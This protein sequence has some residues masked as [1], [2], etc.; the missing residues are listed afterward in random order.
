MTSRSKNVKKLPLKTGNRHTAA[1]RSIKKLTSILIVEYCF[2][3][4]R[5][6]MMKLAAMSACNTRRVTY[7]DVRI[8]IYCKNVSLLP[9]L[10][11][12]SLDS[13]CPFSCRYCWALLIHKA[14]H[15]HLQRERV[16]SWV[17]LKILWGSH[18]RNPCQLVPST[19]QDCFVIHETK[20]NTPHANNAESSVV[21][22]KWVLLP[23]LGQ[24]LQKQGTPQVSLP[25]LGVPRSHL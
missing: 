19:F 5:N 13:I 22:R 18:A 12:C 3:L 4:K 14:A 24:S 23:L 2:S 7:R 6:K 20:Q 9:D 25:V 1:D 8:S 15:W 11:Y 17:E 16:C 21:N 10:L